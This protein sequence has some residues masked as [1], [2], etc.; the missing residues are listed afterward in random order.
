MSEWSSCDSSCTGGRT[1]SVQCEIVSDS[2][3]VRVRIIDCIAEDEKH[4]SMI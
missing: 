4:D 3:I 2:Q 1:R